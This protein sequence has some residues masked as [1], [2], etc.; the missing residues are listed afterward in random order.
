M[1]TAEARCAIEA[2]C[3]SRVETV[4]D[5]LVGVQLTAVV[6]DAIME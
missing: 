5:D 3:E 1:S 6:P 2:Y 4:G